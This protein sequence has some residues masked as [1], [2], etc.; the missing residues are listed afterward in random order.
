MSGGRKVKKSDRGV[1]R[2]GTVKE[3]PV[4]EKEEEI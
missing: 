3:K 4:V 2:R 1:M